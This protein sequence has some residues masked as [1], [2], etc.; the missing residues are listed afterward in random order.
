MAGYCLGIRDCL[1]ILATEVK[2]WVSHFQRVNNVRREDT[3]KKKI[4]DK[5]KQKR[6]VTEQTT[7]K[8]IAFCLVGIT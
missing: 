3:E 2:F 8:I 6:N 1:G 4:K 7:G 5:T